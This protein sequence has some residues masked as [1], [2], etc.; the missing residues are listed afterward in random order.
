MTSGHKLAAIIFIWF[1][2]GSLA[3]FMP[4]MAYSVSDTWA[5]LLYGLLI[6]GAALATGAVAFA[7]GPRPLDR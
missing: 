5:V 2:A 3:F 7:P 1:V 6:V 4:G